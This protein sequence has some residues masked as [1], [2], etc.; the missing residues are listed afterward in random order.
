[1]NGKDFKTTDCDFLL[2]CKIP[3]GE[4]HQVIISKEVIVDAINKYGY[5]QVLDKPLAIDFNKATSIDEL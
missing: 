2:L 3:S 4:V 1:M 5:F